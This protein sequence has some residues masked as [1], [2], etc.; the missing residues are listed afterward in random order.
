MVHPAPEAS[1]RLGGNVHFGKALASLFLAFLMPLLL[2]AQSNSTPEW[3]RALPQPEYN[4]LQRV[5]ESDSW[6]KGYKAAPGLFA[7]YEP[8]QAEEV[9][10]YLI[11]GHKQAVLFDTGMGI[12][13]IH[14]VITQLTSPP[15][16]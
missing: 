12:A 14:R 8:H 1:A 13:N 9:I 7:I 5:C 11:V 15:V 6:C 3:C 16:V 2:A 4:E 10:S